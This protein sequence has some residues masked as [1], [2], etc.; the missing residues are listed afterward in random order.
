MLPYVRLLARLLDARMRLLYV[1]TDVDREGVIVSGMVSRQGASG[2]LAP[3]REIERRSCELLHQQAEI[4]RARQ[5]ETSRRAPTI[6]A[7]C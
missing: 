3:Y 4:Y 6:P 2:N 1:L 5:A 7:A